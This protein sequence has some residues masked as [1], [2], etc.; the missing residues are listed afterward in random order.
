MSFFYSREKYS[1][2]NVALELQRVVYCRTKYW[3]AKAMAA[4]LWRLF[5]YPQEGITL[6]FDNGETTVISKNYLYLI[7]AVKYSSS[8]HAFE[9]SRVTTL[10]S[11]YA[12]NVPDT[13]PAKHRYAF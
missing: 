7:P 12:P 4:P 2:S 8:N 3:S 10:S 13:G 9:P 1:Y 6:H 5:W 11:Y